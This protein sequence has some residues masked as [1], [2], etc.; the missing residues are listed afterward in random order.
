MGSRAPPAGHDR[1]RHRHHQGRPDPQR[2]REARSPLPEAHPDRGRGRL[3]PRPAREPGRPLGG[4]GGGEQG[5][6]ARRPR[7]RLARDR[8]RAAARPGSR[9]CGSTTVPSR[10]RSSW[11][12]SGS[13]CRS[14]T[15]ASTP[16]RSRTASGPQGGDLRVPARHRRAPRRSR[17]GRSSRGWSACGRSTREPSRRSDSSAAPGGRAG[18]R[19]WSGRRAA[20]ADEPTT[21]AAMTAAPRVIELDAASAASL[22]PRRD[23]AGHKGT[24]GRV[25]L[26][27]G[28]LDYAGAALLAGSAALRGGAGLAS[29]FVPA[30]LQ[31][32]LAGRVPELITRSPS[33]GRRRARWTP[34]AGGGDR[35]GRAPRRARARAGARPGSVD[36]AARRAGCSRPPARP[37]SW[38]RERSPRSRRCRRWWRRVG[39][40]CV[41]TPHPGEFARLTGEGPADRRR[42]R[43][44]RRPRPPRRWGQVVVLKGARTVVAAPAPGTTRRSPFVLPLLATAGTGDVLAG[45][46]GA[47]LAQ[48]LAPADAAALGR[49]PPRSGRGGADGASRGCGPPRERPP[50]RAAACTGVARRR[51]ADRRPP[52]CE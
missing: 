3:R 15:S 33:R 21:P 31:P 37:R 41:L 46:I 52:P 36:R 45:L 38:T 4:E 7:R 12:W 34:V 16:S 42:T 22:V 2:A 35:R 50:R 29:L 20:A 27:A 25:A 13:R 40:A 5:A 24:F 1:A 18:E 17:A 32:V 28:S 14:A 9:P 23:P 44:E 48:G 6:R 51:R 39:R 11:A 10:A 43:S 49:L 30:S 47:L 19:G 26:V 8:D